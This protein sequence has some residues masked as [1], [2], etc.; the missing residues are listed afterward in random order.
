MAFDGVG[1]FVDFIVDKS[2]VRDEVL[3]GV[4]VKD[5]LITIPRHFEE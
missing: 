4:A 5:V 3:G 1:D 2:E